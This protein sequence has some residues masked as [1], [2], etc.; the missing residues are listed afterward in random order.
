MKSKIIPKQ[1][2][3]YFTFFYGNIFLALFVGIFLGSSPNVQEIKWGFF[4][5]GFI[6]LIIGGWLNQK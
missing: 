4:T 1:E 3:A 6:L 5:V 2:I